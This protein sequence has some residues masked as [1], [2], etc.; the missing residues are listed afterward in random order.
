LRGSLHAVAEP[1]A[2]EDYSGRF[3]IESRLSSFAV[4]G[5]NMLG[6][7]LKELRVIKVI[8]PLGVVEWPLP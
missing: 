1:V 5:V 7:R 6:V 8:M 3:E 4:V 2:L